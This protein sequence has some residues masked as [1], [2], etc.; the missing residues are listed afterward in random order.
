M[1]VTSTM[2]R[3]IFIGQLAARIVKQFLYFRS[4]LQEFC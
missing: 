2:T 3:R 4:S 1:G